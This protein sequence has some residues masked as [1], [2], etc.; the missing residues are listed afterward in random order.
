MG[1]FHT[2]L[3]CMKRDDKNTIVK[4]ISKRQLHVVSM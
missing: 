1:L 2:I 4:F 3:E